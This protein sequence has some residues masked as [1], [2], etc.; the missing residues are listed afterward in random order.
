MHL[1]PL[2]YIKYLLPLSNISVHFTHFIHIFISIH[3][4]LGNDYEIIA[5]KT[6]L[7]YS[8]PIWLKC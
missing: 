5:V 1:N 6:L 7:C 8:A 4:V 2:F 3:L